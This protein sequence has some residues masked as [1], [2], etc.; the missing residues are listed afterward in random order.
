M[1]EISTPAT[2]FNRDKRWI[3]QANPI[4]KAAESKYLARDK[5]LLEKRRFQRILKEI[6]CEEAAGIKG[7]TKIP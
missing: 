5:F 4:A 6:Q 1:N 7:V 2:N 3:S